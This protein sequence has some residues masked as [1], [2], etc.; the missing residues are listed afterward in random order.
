MTSYH[1]LQ[2]RRKNGRRFDHGVALHLA[3]V[4]LLMLNPYRWLIECRV[5]DVNAQQTTLRGS[6]IHRQESLRQH[7]SISDHV[8]HDF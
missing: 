4:S 3:L 7:Q 1:F 2:V 8:I 5:L 6:A